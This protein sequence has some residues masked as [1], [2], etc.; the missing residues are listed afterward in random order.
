MKYYNIGISDDLEII[1]YYPQTELK[2]GYNPR[3]NGCFDVNN[4]SFPDFVPNYELELHSK[5]FP[6][7]FLPRAGAS[8]GMI[9]NE[10]TKRVFQEHILPP[11]AF[12]PMKVYHNEII[13]KYYWFHCI[14]NDFWRLI[15]AENSFAE[16]FNFKTRTVVRKILI[17]SRDQIINEIKKNKYPLT[18]RL[19]N[20]KMN[21][22][23]FNY[24]FY[25][26]DAFNHKIISKRLKNA[27]EAADVTGHITTP[28]DKI[29]F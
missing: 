2:K 28:F 14:P 16:V 26:I 1:G 11:H 5:A 13:L 6:T 21:S 3:R 12:Y 8:F 24:D 18:L 29:T 7:G 23:F 25:K 4:H 15:D 27:L 9:V 19:G 17:N 10:K 22:D 20:L